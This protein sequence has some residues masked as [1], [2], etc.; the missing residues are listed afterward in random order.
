MAVRYF[1]FGKT[2]KNLLQPYLCPIFL[3]ISII[4]LITFKKNIMANNDAFLK[5]IKDGYIFKGESIKI[6]KRSHKLQKLIL[7]H[8]FIKPKILLLNWELEK[9][10]LH[11]CYKKH[12]A[13]CW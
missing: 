13:Y 12:D 1:V 2:I 10:W 5:Q 4:N 3:R 11:C 8:L 7:K 6:A 9:R